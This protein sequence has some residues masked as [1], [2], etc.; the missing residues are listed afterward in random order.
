MGRVWHPKAV[1]LEEGEHCSEE[2]W[3]GPWQHAEDAKATADWT[4]PKAGL[5]L[6]E[7][8]LGDTAEGV[9]VEIELPLTERPHLTLKQ[10]RILRDWAKWVQETALPNGLNDSSAADLAQ[11]PLDLAKMCPRARALAESAVSDLRRKIEE[12]NVHRIQRGHCWRSAQQVVLKLRIEGAQ[13]AEEVGQSTFGVSLDGL[14][15]AVAAGDAVLGPEGPNLLQQARRTLRESVRQET[16]QRCEFDPHKAYAYV[17]DSLPEG[18]S[19]HKRHLLSVMAV[20]SSKAVW[21]DLARERSGEEGEAT[22]ASRLHDAGI[23]RESYWTEE[24][25]RSVQLRL[26]GKIAFATPDVLF[27]RRVLI[28]GAQTVHWI[29]S[30]GS[31]LL[32]GFV[33]ASQVQKLQR[34]LANFVALFGPGLVVWRGGFAHAATECLEGVHTG[35][36]PSRGDVQVQQEPEPKCETGSPA[37]AAREAWMRWQ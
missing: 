16:T 28:N 1:H 19:E 24:D 2:N 20:A 32:P 10:C 34:Q 25:L 18:I 6:K 11:A 4:D 9:A 15:R 14:C 8:G 12:K 5:Y 23:D 3:A 29:D 27:H 26:F 36:W 33:F 37:P 31:C 17:R 22:L 35:A 7:L 21:A 30:K 13:A